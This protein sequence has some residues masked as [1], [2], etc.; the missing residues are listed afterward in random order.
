[1]K[2]GK[3]A[4][5]DSGANHAATANKALKPIKTVGVTLADGSEVPLK[6]TEGDTIK[7]PYGNQT[8]LP[9]IKMGET[10]Q[11]VFQITR[12]GAVL[13][14]PTKGYVE[15]EIVN[16]LKGYG[17]DFIFKRRYCNIYAYYVLLAR[18]T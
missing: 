18:C 2:K 9:I 12:D 3:R 4:L 8:I 14:H 5:L 1:M 17:W 7:V 16:V 11:T 10:L 6:I 13:W 15:V